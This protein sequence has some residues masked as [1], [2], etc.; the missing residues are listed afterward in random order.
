MWHV[1]NTAALL[2][3]IGTKPPAASAK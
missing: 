1:Q 2:Q 3:Q